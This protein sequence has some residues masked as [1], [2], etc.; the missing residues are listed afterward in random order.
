VTGKGLPKLNDKGGDNFNDGGHAR[1][2]LL[3]N[4]FFGVPDPRI[5][6]WL[7]I[8]MTPF[9]ISDFQDANKLNKK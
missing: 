3:M 5:H 2:F 1:G 9:S 4:L 6:T 8:R 7:R